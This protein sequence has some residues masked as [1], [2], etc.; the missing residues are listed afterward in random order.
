MFHV[1]TSHLSNHFCMFGIQNICSRLIFWNDKK[2]INVAE[3][4]T[5]FEII[6]KESLPHSLRLPDFN[7]LFD[8][9]KRTKTL[10]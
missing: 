10:I 1:F 7:Q 5:V 4:K 2:P 6:K 9:I 8:V 3:T